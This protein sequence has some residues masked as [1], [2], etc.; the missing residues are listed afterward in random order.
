MFNSTFNYDIWGNC[1][2]TREV[3]TRFSSTFLKQPISQ[4]AP[5][6]VNGLSSEQL[7]PRGMLCLVLPHQCYSSE[8]DSRQNQ[9]V[10]RTIRAFIP[11]IL[12]NLS[13]SL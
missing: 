4:F 8:V 11:A 6:S 1:D 5:P 13:A 12:L 9:E 7:H 10:N 2:K 3:G